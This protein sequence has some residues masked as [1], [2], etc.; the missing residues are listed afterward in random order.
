MLCVRACSVKDLLMNVGDQF[1]KG[2]IKAVWK[3][4]PISGGKL[5]YVKFVQIIKRGKEEAEAAK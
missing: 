4:A 1:D 2:E 3:E 5:D